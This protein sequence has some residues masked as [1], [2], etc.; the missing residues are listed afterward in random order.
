M[1]RVQEIHKAITELQDELDEIR[2][3]CT[4]KEVHITDYMYRIASMTRGYICDFCGEF[5]GKMVSPQ[6]W[7]L[8]PNSS[9]I[10]YDNIKEYLLQQEFPIK[11]VSWNQFCKLT[12]YDNITDEMAK[13]WL[14]AKSRDQKIDEITKDENSKN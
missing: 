12:N 10:P 2:K 8:H 5:L 4:H 11:D 9:R 3:N 14:K 1:S 6:E 13:N 7:I